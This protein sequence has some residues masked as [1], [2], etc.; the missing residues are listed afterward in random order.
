MNELTTTTNNAVLTAQGFNS[1]RFAEAWE[2]WIKDRAY[3]TQAG[4]NVTVKCFLEWIA[5]EGIKH[6]EEQHHIR[7]CNHAQVRGKR[8]RKDLLQAFCQKIPLIRKP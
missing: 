2:A 8:F 5:R 3:T 1:S 6:P 7:I 4:Y